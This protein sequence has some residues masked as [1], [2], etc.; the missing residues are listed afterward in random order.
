MPPSISLRPATMNDA[1]ILLDWVNQPD[2]LAHKLKTTKPIE[3]DQHSAWLAR[4]LESEACLLWI[5]EA[6]GRPVGQVRFQKTDGSRW[7]IDIYIDAACRGSGAA[8]YA[9]RT[10]AGLLALREPS[11]ILQADVKAVNQASLKLFDRLGFTMEQAGPDYS[12]FFV[13]IGDIK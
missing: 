13:R 2:S 9:I 12:T 3:V 10:A 7:N 11:A 8:Q 1:G 6:E 4:A 5:L